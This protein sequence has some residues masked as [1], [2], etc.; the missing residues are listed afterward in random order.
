MA[1]PDVGG[2]IYT[3]LIGDGTLSALVGT[4]VYEIQAPQGVDP[5]YV[6][7]V[8]AGGGEGNVT[9]RRS[10]NALFLVKGVAETRAGAVA[11][12][13]AIS[14]ALH[15][16]EL[17]VSGWHNYDV[18]RESHSSLVENLQGTQVWHKGA[19]YRV[20]LAASTV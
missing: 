9:P 2:A 12:D 7:F 16:Q 19:W 3:K 1:E 14:G 17:T 10:K 6:I 20:R 11:V 4:K 5:P 15:L 8:P 18:Q 13:S